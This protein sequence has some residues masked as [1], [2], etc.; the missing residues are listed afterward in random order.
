MIDRQNGGTPIGKKLL[1]LSDR[2]FTWWHRV[3]GGTLNRSSFQVY[4]SGLRAEVRE[5]LLQGAACGCSKTAATCRNLTANE[6]KL[7]AFVWHEGVEPTNNAVE[8][9]LRHAVLWRKGSG[10]TDSRR[11]SRFVER[12]LSVR[13]TCRQQGRSLLEYLLECCQAHGSGTDAPSLLPQ[14]HVGLEVA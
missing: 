4:I 3:R 13:E 9:S 8:R 12:V 5:A 10:G 6:S 14:G 11:G 7:W 2:M 1:D